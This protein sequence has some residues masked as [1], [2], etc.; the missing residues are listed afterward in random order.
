M[1]TARFKPLVD[2]AYGPY[3][4]CHTVSPMMPIGQTPRPKARQEWP[5]KGMGA[6]GKPMAKR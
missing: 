6:T 1:K 2:R 5:A 3:E 4:P